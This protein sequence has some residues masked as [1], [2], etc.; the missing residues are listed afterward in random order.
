MQTFANETGNTVGVEKASVN[1]EA[2]FYKLGAAA[3]FTSSQL[4]INLTRG[5]Y[6]IELEVKESA[7]GYVCIGFAQ[8]GTNLLAN[9]VGAVANSW[10]YYGQN[11]QKY[12]AG[13]ASAFGPNVRSGDK[14]TMKF[15]F[16]SPS[17]RVFKNAG[18]IGYLND[19]PFQNNNI[20]VFVTMYQP[21]ENVIVRVRVRL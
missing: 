15:S 18:L 10:C 14:I 16:D 6:K 13:A 7:T 2:R 20:R 8:A 5:K 3:G 9:Y 4:P 21:G 17:V 12:I 1:Y 19:I 11:G